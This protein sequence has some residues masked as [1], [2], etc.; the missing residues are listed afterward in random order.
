MSKGSEKP[1]VSQ[2]SASGGGP[3]RMSDIARAA[4]VSVVTVSRSLN[5]PD[6]VSSETRKRVIDAMER[7]GYVPDQVA[8][9]LVTRRS[10]AIG[11]VIPTVTNS[12]FADTIEGISDVMEPRGYQ[13]MIGSSRYDP[14]VEQA[15][16]RTFLS[17]RA[18]AIILTGV[19]HTPFTRRLLEHS[20]VPVVEMWNLCDDP[21]DTLVGFSNFEA[22]RQMTLYL[23][24][25]GYRNIAFMGGDTADND[26]TTH[27]ELGY[28]A[29]LDDLG[30][31][32]RQEWIERGAFD[33]RNGARG[34]HRLLDR[35]PEVDAVFT[36]SDVL[37]LGAI[38]ECM[39]Q[40]WAVPDRVAIAGLD[41]SVIAKEVV[42]ALTTVRI[43]R[44]KIGLRIGEILLN[45]LEG[46]ET[47]AERV[48][49]GF[50]IIR[51]DSA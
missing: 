45:R 49:L 14:E 43:P 24:Q 17:R 28:L 44:H 8:G 3:V 15:L 40:G 13:L 36:A 20:G 6:K 7:T 51:R 1:S 34:L 39:R 41:D 47:A 21:I 22:A 5:H 19:T 48:D 12:L 27:R 29:A 16:V 33:V 50:E 2:P 25:R 18:D 31:Q 42:P 26:R 38:F 46:R 30:L 23:G 35:C 11:L 10:H 4:G 9:S 32:S 37:A